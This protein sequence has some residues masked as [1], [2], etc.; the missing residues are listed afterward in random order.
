MDRY[1]SKYSLVLVN[2]STF[3]LL[4]KIRKIVL[5]IQGV[6]GQIESTAYVNITFPHL[7]C[8]NEKGNNYEKNMS[9]DFDKNDWI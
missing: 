3:L 6:N 7:L 9:K 2:A 4:Y 5:Y 8:K 1:R